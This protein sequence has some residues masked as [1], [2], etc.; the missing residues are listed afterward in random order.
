MC[1]VLLPV[2]HFFPRR[3]D[4]KF[5][6]RD[7]ESLY[8][9]HNFSTIMTGDCGDGRS[10]LKFHISCDLIFLCVFHFF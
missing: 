3:R 8:D 5:I 2:V 7:F 6:R 9:I 10:Y 4:L 1:V